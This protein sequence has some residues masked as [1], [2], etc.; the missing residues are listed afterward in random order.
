MNNF[1][2]KQLNYEFFK[3]EKNHVKSSCYPIKFQVQEN[4]DKIDTDTDVVRLK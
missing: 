3:Q 1:S 4:S 2:C